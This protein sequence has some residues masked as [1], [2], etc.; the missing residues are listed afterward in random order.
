MADAFR[1][2]DL[3]S[4]MTVCL[5]PSA[6]RGA[7]C[8]DLSPI[9]ICQSIVRE[10]LY[11]S[12][13]ML[14]AAESSDGGVVSLRPPSAPIV[15]CDTVD[16][17]ARL[18]AAAQPWRIVGDIESV[19]SLTI[20]R[21][22][23]L[24]GGI[25]CTMVLFYHLDWVGSALPP[26]KKGPL[27][28]DESVFDPRSLDCAPLPS[29][30]YLLRDLVRGDPRHLAHIR[31]LNLVALVA[32]VLE[33]LPRESDC[34]LTV[35]L[36]RAMQALQCALD[37]Q[38]G[39]S[40]ATYPETSQL[41]SQVQRD[42]LLNLRIWR[43]ADLSTQFAYLKEAHRILCA[44]RHGGERQKRNNASSGVCESAAGDDAIGVRWILY[45]LFNFYPY[46]SSQHL[47]QQRLPQQPRSARRPLS[48][49]T[50]VLTREASAYAEGFGGMAGLPTASTSDSAS[51]FSE[52]F[53]TG[54]DDGYGLGDESGDRPEGDASSF[55]TLSCEET[56]RLRR[57][58]LH[59]LEL[60]LSAC[61]DKDAHN[62][63]STP[64]PHASKSDVGHLT[65]HL[66]YACNRD[67]RHTKE[68]LQLLFRCLADGS[69]NASQLSAKLLNQH[70]LDALCH[71]IECD[72]DSV[73]AEAIN[74]IVLLLTMTVAMR[75][76]E[77]AASRFT[78]SLRGR[79]V[80]MVELDDIPRVLALVRAKRALTP[81]LYRSLL[82]LAFCDHASLLAS[83]NV[84]SGVAG[85][86]AGSLAPRSSH[87][88]NLS[89][90]T[91]SAL[92]ADDDIT[93]DLQTSFVGAMPA[94]LI[95]V[96]EAWSAILELSCAPETDPDICVAVLNDLG[97]LLDDEPANVER[98]RSLQTPILD[99]LVTICVLS[100][101]FAD[102]SCD[103]RIEV[104]GVG[105][106]DCN[107]MPTQVEDLA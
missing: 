56:R 71:I 68:V 44:G 62:T 22:M 99:H 28:S 35:A 41:W 83:L 93:Q 100:G 52:G 8:L 50:S 46:D 97:K 76:S 90:P 43:K 40:P 20:H 38:G 21:A 30:L 7:V 10:N 61:K 66:L 32:H 23:Y 75:E 104:A 48:V 79:A 54:S 57:V 63:R 53:A 107:S 96:V 73:A 80:A 77:S 24:L 19:N 81:A 16:A 36:L 27:G 33:Q 12:A 94:R 31:S 69:P 91:A 14:T 78:N 92:R 58:I 34:H 45:A 103:A 25:E 17:K 3:A 67:S 86:M 84:D 26:A 13:R 51:A 55:P 37:E 47:A 87:V 98:I 4:R 82:L 1:S 95:Q 88:R 85:G 9:G 65:R 29:L 49:R 15:A 2:N 74:I 70:G 42:L 101:H 72:D 39:L 89:I 60:F 5:D 102:S 105:A 11:H 6:C 64:V 59:T 106:G 18:D